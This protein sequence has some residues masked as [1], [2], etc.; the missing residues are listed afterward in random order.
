MN[1]LS[2]RSHV[3][4]ITQPYYYLMEELSCL[5]RTIEASVRVTTLLNVQFLNE[6][7]SIRVTTLLKVLSHR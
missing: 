1:V 6:E 4:L 5:V 3:G 2:H 7:L